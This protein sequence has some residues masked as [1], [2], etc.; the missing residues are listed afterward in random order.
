MKG[1]GISSNVVSGDINKIDDKIT[2]LN[3]DGLSSDIVDSVLDSIAVSNPLPA[4]GGKNEE[5]VDEI[6]Y[7]AMAA[8]ASQNRA[9]TL[10]DYIARVYSLPAK[11]GSVAKAF[12][13]QNDLIN[14]QFN[15]GD[16]SVITNPHVFGYSNPLAIDLYVL[17]FDKDKKLQPAT[18]TV[19]ENLQTYLSQYRILTDA[20]N[21][22][23]AL[24]C[25]IGI[26]FEIVPRLNYNGKATILRCIEA[27][28][29]YFDIDK[30]QIYQP[31]ILSDVLNY[32][33]TVEGVQMVQKC[34][35]INKVSI[36]SAGMLWMK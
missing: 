4:V 15:P 3:S 31:I 10:E 25:N 29:K 12:V 23:D 2:L 8:Y 9:V 7:N 34:E 28:K 13:A 26:D 27:L 24:V 35:F 19:K 32:L 16:G 18:V 30:W 11:F 14:A 17:A 36:S 20:I 33:D 6:R 21:I 1:G 5:S 22:R